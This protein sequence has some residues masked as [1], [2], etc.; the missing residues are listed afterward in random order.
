M[1]FYLCLAAQV[2]NENADPITLN[3]YSHNIDILRGR[4][5]RDGLPGVK[6]E[7][8]EKGEPGPSAGGVTFTRWG[9]STCP[10]TSKTEL[11]YEGLAAGGSYGNSG[12]GANYV[13]VTKS[14]EYLSSS[15][16]PYFSYLQGAAYKS[17]ISR[18]SLDDQNVPCAVCYSSI[19]L[20]KLM[21]PGKRTCPSSW[22]KEYSGYLMADFY[23][24]KHNSVYECIDE[25]MDGIS[26]NGSA[27][28]KGARMYHVIVSCG[29]GHGLPCPPYEQNKSLTCVV[30]TK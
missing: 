25:E 28:S 23:D 16:S 15:T 20:T 11:V 21:I 4:D 3:V 30:C 13:C 12:G 18:P 19:R 8:G 29:S 10:N 6:G 26:N 5:G 9:K 14:P 7:K 2:S 27:T 24:H 22:T 17:V 1:L